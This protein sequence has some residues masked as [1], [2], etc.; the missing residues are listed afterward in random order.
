MSIKILTGWFR[1][2]G[3]S[4]AHINLTNAFNKHGI[5]CTL[6]GIND[7]YFS[8]HCKS[9]KLHDMKLEED[10]HLI[11]HFFNTN[12]S[13]KPPINGKF[14]YSCHEK[15]ICKMS[16]FP[17]Q[18]YDAIHYVSEPQRKWHNINHRSIVL[19]NIIDELK[20]SKCQNNKIS[21]IIGNIDIN[22]Q[23]HIS[24]QRALDDGM[25]RVLLFGNISDQQYYNNAVEPLIDG[26]KVLYMGHEDDKQKMYNSISHVYHSSLSETFGLV[27]KECELTR[28]EYHGNEATKDNFEQ[29]MTNDEIINEWCKELEI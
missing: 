25:E 23:I 20:Q 2:G 27:Q 24:I 28:V 15:D 9:G 3:S 16:S 7:N 4:T 22:K 1:E 11:I 5:D 12:W 8:K 21:G 19:P 29:N 14:I 10:D 17:Y 13:K 18:I 6:Y 26:I